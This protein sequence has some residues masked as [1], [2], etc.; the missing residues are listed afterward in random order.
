MC[1]N[2][3]SWIDHIHES[4]LDLKACTIDEYTGLKFDIP[5][6]YSQAIQLFRW[7]NYFPIFLKLYSNSIES[8]VFVTHDDGSRDEN[9]ITKP[10]RDETIWDLP[11]NFS[12]WITRDDDYHWI[13]N[14]DI[15]FFFTGEENQ[16]QFLTDAYIMKLCQ[17]ILFYSPFFRPLFYPS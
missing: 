1:S 11:E 17:E 14:I 7:D 9:F 13:L 6:V 8:L 2:L 12:Y 3:D 5:K 10:W 15:D 4:R 16:I